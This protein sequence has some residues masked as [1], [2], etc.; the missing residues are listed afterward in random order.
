M[1]MLVVRRS[2]WASSNLMGLDESAL[3]S[4][5]AGVQGRLEPASREQIPRGPGEGEVAGDAGE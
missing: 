2:V 5:P 4:A 1:S 3:P